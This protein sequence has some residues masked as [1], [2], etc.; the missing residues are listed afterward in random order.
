MNH[1]E[2]FVLPVVFA[3]TAFFPA[4]A[5]AQPN[6][7][8]V[9]TITVPGGLAGYDINWVD[10]GS[11]RYYLADRTATKGTGRI[12]VVDTRNMTLLYTIPSTK[13]EIG[14]SGT[15]PSKV[16]GCSLSGPNGVVAIPQ[17]HQLYV[18][19]GDST[20]KV[21]DLDARAVVATIPTG[22]SCRAD[23]LAY[24]AVD[25]IVMIANDQES[26]PFLTFISTDTLA[27]LGRLMYPVNQI[28]QGLEQPVW[29]PKNDRFYQAVP[30]D[31]GRIDVINPLTMQ[32][33]R[34]FTTKCSPAGLVLTPNQRLM[35]SCGESFDAISGNSLG[36]QNNAQ[37]DQLW[38]NPGDNYHYFGY[39]NGTFGPFSGRGVAV[40]DNNTNQLLTFIPASTHSLAVDPNYNRIF[41][42]VSGS[43][44]QVWATK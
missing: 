31:V 40:V 20:V 43:G 37:A 28:G 14:F 23:E 12:D 44:I 25:H 34:S 38:Y 33:E 30:G 11:E 24:D 16:P 13:N 3:T 19:D 17:Q 5:F 22:G 8:L 1:R 29:N 39:F 18:G 4:G 15:V 2:L 41:I 7:Q 21:V 9:T 36:W 10:P 6:Y 42:P 27:V 35:T 26:P 32:V